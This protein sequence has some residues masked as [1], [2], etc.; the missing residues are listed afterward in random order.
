MLRFLFVLL[1]I[2]MF[3]ETSFEQKMESNIINGFYRIEFLAATYVMEH[4]SKVY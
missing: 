2:T 4:L 3:L 1:F